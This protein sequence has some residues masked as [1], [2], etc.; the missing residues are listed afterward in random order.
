M[1]LTIGA[2][3]LG[4]SASAYLDTSIG[5]LLSLLEGAIL[6]MIYTTDIAKKFKKK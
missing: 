6:V 4:Y 3:G 2:F 5:Y 1:N